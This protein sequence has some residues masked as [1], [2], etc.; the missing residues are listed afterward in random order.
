MAEFMSELVC[1]GCAQTGHITWDG[2]G[3][4]RRVVSMS[5]TIQEHPGDPPS[6]TCLKCGTTQVLI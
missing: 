1:A 6:F 2:N 3:P 4:D 5:D